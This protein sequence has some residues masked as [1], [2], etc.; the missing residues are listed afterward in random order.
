M[1]MYGGTSLMRT[2]LGQPRVSYVDILCHVVFIKRSSTVF[3]T[4]SSYMY[5]YYYIFSYSNCSFSLMVA[6]SSLRGEGEL[7]ELGCVL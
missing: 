3:S 7:E 2:P 5:M 6:V 4:V 1:Y